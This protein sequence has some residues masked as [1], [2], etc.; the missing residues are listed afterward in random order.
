MEESKTSSDGFEELSTDLDSS[1]IEAGNKIDDHH[2]RFEQDHP[3]IQKTVINLI[4]MFITDS[5]EG[6][7]FV[8]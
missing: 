3:H 7:R 5:K 6:V 4:K 8:D 1:R 2:E